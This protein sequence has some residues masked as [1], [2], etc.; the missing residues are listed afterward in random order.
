V[1]NGL[2]L[3]LDAGNTQ[4]YPG[5]GT[6]WSDLSGN[7]KNG[8]LFNSPTYSTNNLG[9]IVFDGIDDYATTNLTTNYINNSTQSI[10]YKWNGIN[11]FATLT[12]LG[13]A[14]GNGLG[15]LI[16]NG[17]SNAIGNRIGILYG[18]FSFN[19][20]ATSVILTSGLWNNLV[21]TRDSTTTK[22]YN[23]G[24]FFDFTTNSPITSASYNFNYGN[25]L[26]Y[27]AG[28]VVSNISFYNRDLNAT[29]IL[30]NYNALK[31]RYSI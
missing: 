23:N 18:G 8:G 4:S 5:T 14:G 22:L 6:T 31:G 30:Q 11:Q 13:D 27:A 16:H 15:L 2:I 7:N 17:T 19:A 12:Y 25:P 10:W 24:N 29:E 21:I 9:S 26:S 1:T 3:F 20:L 28:G